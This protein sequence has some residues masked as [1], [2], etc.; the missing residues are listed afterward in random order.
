MKKNVQVKN[1][2]GKVFYYAEYDEK[3]NWIYASWKGFV[4][5]DDVKAGAEKY[6]EFMKETGCPHLLNDNSELTGPWD[7][8]NEWIANDWTPRALAA[9]LKNFAHIVSPNVFGE[10]SAKN[11]EVKLEK[12]GFTMK[13][14]KQSSEAANWLKKQI[15]GTDGLYLKSA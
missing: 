8:A 2:L 5:V 7:G 6:L 14:F 10:I 13:T 4:T 12:M 3:N 1:R 9:G 15:K 11:M